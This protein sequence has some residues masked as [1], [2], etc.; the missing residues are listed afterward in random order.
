MVQKTYYKIVRGE[1]TPG[2]I[3]GRVL[4]RIEFYNRRMKLTILRILNTEIVLVL[5]G[6]KVRRSIKQMNNKDIPVTGRVDP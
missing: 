1:D 3:V 2:G 6:N 4:I 5:R